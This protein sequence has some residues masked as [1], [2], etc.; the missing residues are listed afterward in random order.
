MDKLLEGYRRFRAQEWPERRAMFER[1]AEGQSPRTMVI[2]CA[3]SRVD[4]SM[5][6]GTAPGELLVIRNVAALVPPYAPDAAYHG[7][8]AALEF[9]VNV[10]RVK[11]VIVLGH[12]L[13]GG[14][15]ALISGAPEEAPD[16]LGPWVSIALRAVDRA[17][18]GGAREDLQTR[19][20]KEAIRVSL[21]NLMTFPWLA[22]RVLAGDL[23]LRGGHFD[24]RTGV[25]IMTDRAGTFRPV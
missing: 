7:T 24:I 4:P 12:G 17:L 20:E 16:F 14:I 19:C 3:D 1:L 5:I 22:A 13:C 6:F 18:A 11:N 9:G 23:N 25:L 15:Q 21:E 2:G 10:L 8:S